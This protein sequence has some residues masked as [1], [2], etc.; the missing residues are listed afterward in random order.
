MTARLSTKSTYSLP[1]KLNVLINYIY[2]LTANASKSFLQVYSVI[3]RGH[4]RLDM[5]DRAGNI[6]TGNYMAC[7]H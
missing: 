5:S 2:I 4:N 6:N 1:N 7:S 3:K